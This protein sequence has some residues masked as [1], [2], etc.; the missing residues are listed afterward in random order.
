MQLYKN[1]SGNSGVVA[2]E[3]GDHYI[4]VKFKSGEIYNYTYKSAGKGV[5]EEMKALAKSGNGLSTYI[6]RNNPPFE[7]KY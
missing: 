5:I 1:I 3:A 7:E 6:S 4:K 2:Y